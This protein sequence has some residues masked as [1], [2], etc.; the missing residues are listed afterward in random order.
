M[1]LLSADCRWPVTEMR[2]VAA[3]VVFGVAVMA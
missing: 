2:L 1:L 3:I